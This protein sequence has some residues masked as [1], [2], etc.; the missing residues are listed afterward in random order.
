MKERLEAL[1][2]EALEQLSG[3]N[4]PQTLADLRVKYLVKRA[5]TEILRGMGSLSAEERP[6]IGQV[7][8]D[9][10]GAIEEVINSKQEQFQKEETAK[11]LQSEKIDVTLPGRRGR[12][13]GLHPLTKS[14][15]GN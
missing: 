15:T 9:V 14:G 4:D 8:N 11:R 10:R 1:K 6:V 5:L 7:G 3:V 12:Q 13:G 2:I